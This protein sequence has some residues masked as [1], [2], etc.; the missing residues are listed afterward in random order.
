[1]VRALADHFTKRTADEGDSSPGVLLSSGYI[2][3]GSVAAILIIFL[4]LIPGFSGWLDIGSRLGEEWNA[5][6]LPAL[7]SIALLLIPL[8]VTGLQSAEKSRRAERAPVE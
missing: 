3:G 7:L 8:L 5:S 6:N 4:T 2:A 1:M